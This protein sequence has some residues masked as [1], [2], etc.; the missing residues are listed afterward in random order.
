MDF[1]QLVWLAFALPAGS[2]LIGAVFA[3]I[4]WLTRSGE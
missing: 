2:G 4:S 1:G 3:T